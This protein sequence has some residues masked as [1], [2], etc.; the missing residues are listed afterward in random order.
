MKPR[1]LGTAAVVVGLLFTTAPPASAA[2]VTASAS[3]VDRKCTTSLSWAGG[4]PQY[5]H[6]ANVDSRPRGTVVV[7]Y[8]VYKFSDVNKSYDWYAA[9][10]ETKWHRSAGSGSHDAEMG[11]YISSSKW[12][13]D[14]DFGATRT[15]K[16]AVSCDRPVN[17]GMSAGVGIL[18]FS[19]S[20][21]IQACSGQTITRGALRG[22]SAGW[23]TPFVGN[24]PYVETAFEQKV[25]AGRPSY[26]FSVEIPRYTYARDSAGIYRRTATTAWVTYKL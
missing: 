1:S 22:L 16:S 6:I 7:C 8:A 26:T 10:L 14:N 25:T 17:V 20:T 11:Q 15:Y 24:T 21:P 4:E 9:G 13:V 12:A 23:Y 19:A 2:L 3:I 5:T 18:S